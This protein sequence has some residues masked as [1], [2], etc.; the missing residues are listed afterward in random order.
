VPQS[1]EATEEEAS[2]ER[3]VQPLQAR[4]REAAPPRFFKQRSPNEDHRDEGIQVGKGERLGGDVE[5]FQGRRPDDSAEHH[6]HREA[7]EG[8]QVPSKPNTP[9]HD[10]VQQAA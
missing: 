5:R 4:L 6:D 3:T 2:D 1:P 8:E 9:A 7:D 10:P